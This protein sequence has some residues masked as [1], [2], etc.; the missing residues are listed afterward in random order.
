MLP[1]SFAAVGTPRSQLIEQMKL[2]SDNFNIFEYVRFNESSSR[3]LTVDVLLDH[4][5]EDQGASYSQFVQDVHRQL[6]SA[7]QLARRHLKAANQR[8]KNFF[9]H[10]EVPGRVVESL[11]KSLVVLPSHKAR[12]HKE[13]LRAYGRVHTP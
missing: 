12:T 6:H 4:I 7:Q 9:V 11:G 13:F 1:F 10:A 3:S 8:Q 5:P 2:P